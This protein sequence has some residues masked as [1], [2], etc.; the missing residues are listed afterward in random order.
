MEIENDNYDSEHSDEE[1][2]FDSLE[3][4]GPKS[5]H[6]C[7]TCTKKFRISKLLFQHQLLEHKDQKISLL[8]QNLLETEEFYSSDSDCDYTISVE[9]IKTLKPK[10]QFLQENADDAEQVTNSVK[11]VEKDAH[12]D[13]IEDATGDDRISCSYCTQ[14]FTT[15]K[16]LTQHIKLHHV[17]DNGTVEID[18]SSMTTFSCPECLRELKDSRCLKK[19]MKLCHNLKVHSTRRRPPPIRMP[20]KEPS[21]VKGPL[22]EEFPIIRD[23]SPTSGKPRTKCGI[24]GH[25][26]VYGYTTIMKHQVRKHG[27]PMKKTNDLFIC[28]FCTKQFKTKENLSRH[29][30]IHENARRY[31][32]E[33]CDAK[34]N[35]GLLLLR[36]RRLH[37][38]IKCELCDEEFQFR[39]Q[40]RSHHRAAHPKTHK[41]ATMMQ[42]GDND[43]IILTNEVPKV[44]DGNFFEQCLGCKKPFRSKR[45]FK[46]HQC[47]EIDYT[48]DTQSDA[49]M[50]G[51][52]LRKGESPCGICFKSFKSKKGFI[53]HRCKEHRQVICPLDECGLKFDKFRDYYEH[54]E[55]IHNG[56]DENIRA[57]LIYSMD[58]ESEVIQLHEVG[59]VESEITISN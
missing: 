27:R 50:D 49:E 15:K 2:D 35:T 7:P 37:V 55:Q 19:H 30:K 16:I 46:E 40:Y 47:K 59:D 29:L 23:R 26:P 32:C 5:E 43:E 38:Y 9:V 3:Q 45:G 52:P 4:Q 28:D 1:I 56:N 14:S 44:N 11:I 13:K 57:A 51:S 53:N 12:Y 41:S 58:D 20:A 10:S 24:C 17:Q 36:H 34:F 22:C 42:Q 21:V 39:S 8:L 33:L 18:L 25:G 54:V 6:E 31:E 48:E